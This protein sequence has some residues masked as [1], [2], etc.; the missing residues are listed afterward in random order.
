MIGLAHLLWG[1]DLAFLQ[2]FVLLGEVWNLGEMARWL[3]TQEGRLEVREKTQGK[4]TCFG[5]RNL[6]QKL[7]EIRGMLG[8]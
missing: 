3:K 1:K 8:R 4:G 6:G 5:E 7:P 2:A